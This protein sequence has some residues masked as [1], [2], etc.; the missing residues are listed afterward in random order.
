M[1]KH[2]DLPQLFAD[3]G[4][5]VRFLK[6]VARMG[7]DTPTDVQRELIP[8]ILAGKNVLGQ[9]RTGTGKTAAF[10]LPLLQL[11][12]PAGRL[13]VLCLVPTRELAVQVSDEVRQLA[14]FA[15]LRCVPV[16][17]GQRI[18]TQLH[19]L[20]RK[21]HFVVGTPG[22]VF[23]F[24]QR[25][26]LNF[27]SIRAVVLDE[28]DRML[29]IGFRDA[30]RDILNCI[31]NPHQT[32]FVSATVEDEIKRLAQRFAAHPVEV[33]VSRDELMVEEVEQF[34]CSVDQR[35][36]L[37]L[38][39]VLLKEEDPGLAIVFTNTKAQAHR[40]ARRLYESGI[41]AKE[42]HGDLMQKRRERILGS[43]RKHRFK[44]LVAT[45]LV[46]RG[47]DVQ[48][49]TH[50]INYDLPQDTE[51]YVH[52]IGRT[53][54]MG[55]NG[56]AITFVTPDQGKALTDV[57]KLINVLIQDKRYAGFVPRVFEDDQPK[58][59]Q[60]QSPSRYQQPV[61]SDMSS[62]DAVP[63]SAPVKT[64]GSKFRPRRRRRR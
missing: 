35:D 29:D 59:V 52:R 4:V 50:I 62:S 1:Q 11:C 19:A 15:D 56:K 53:A 64:L 13:Q 17:G 9:A 46:G 7:F 60:P 3:L 54:R 41:D 5:E 25:R 51:A 37:R 39:K 43:F 48:A 12:D 14:Q 27:D 44:V 8:L 32:V 2:T 58:A 22:R 45:D 36:K 6:A 55:A 10:G 21:P 49:I 61:F 47:I 33:D 38:L 63:A 40:V 28:V 31:R 57:E 26:A 16:Y 18:Q 20:G 42:I 24:I 30:I 23:D 34:C